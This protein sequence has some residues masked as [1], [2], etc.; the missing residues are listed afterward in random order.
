MYK[1]QMLSNADVQERYP[2]SST[3]TV[4]KFAKEAIDKGYQ[5]AQIEGENFS[6]C[7]GSDLLY[8]SKIAIESEF[9]DKAI[10]IPFF[11]DFSLF[12]KNKLIVAFEILGTA[13][14]HGFNNIRLSDH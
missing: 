14:A 11:I 10:R 1:V 5:I 2:I 3:S 7:D 9:P 4:A 12:R 6:T 8:Y 13:C